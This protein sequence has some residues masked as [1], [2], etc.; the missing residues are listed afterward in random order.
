MVTSDSIMCG[1]GLPL[2]RLSFT[3]QKA[4]CFPRLPW[5]V[6]WLCV[7]ARGGWLAARQRARQSVK[8]ATSRC[9]RAIKG[10]SEQR[11]R[12]RGQTHLQ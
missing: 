7:W 1:D 12:G 11:A 10:E 9:D 8:C 3:V 6:Q 2:L 5:V 4:Q